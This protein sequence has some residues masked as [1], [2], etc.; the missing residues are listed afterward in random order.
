M[1]TDL[2]RGIWREIYA[3]KPI[4]AYRRRLQNTYLEQMA[5][6]INP[7]TPALPPASTGR[8]PPRWRRNSNTRFP[9]NRERRDAFA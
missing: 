8:D 3:G 5:Q 4:D 2:R 1:L 9:R 7:T 6:K